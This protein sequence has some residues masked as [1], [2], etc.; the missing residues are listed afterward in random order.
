MFLSHLVEQM[1]VI[2]LKGVKTYH[3]TVLLNLKQV[4]AQFFGTVVNL[5]KGRMLILLY[6]LEV[7]IVDVFDFF[8]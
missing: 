7:F 6:G 8:I 4:P 3:Q 1:F 5:L 2:F